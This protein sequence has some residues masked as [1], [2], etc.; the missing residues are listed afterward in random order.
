M[1]IS[2][3]PSRGDRGY[4]V[5]SVRL[6]HELPALVQADVHHFLLLYVPVARS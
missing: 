3:K 1:T 2:S 6:I 4:V 5:G